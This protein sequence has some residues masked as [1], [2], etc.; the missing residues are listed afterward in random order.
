MHGEAG[1]AFLELPGLHLSR[2]A[3]ARS[4]SIPSL[5][6][7]TTAY[8]LNVYTGYPLEILRSLQIWTWLDRRADGRA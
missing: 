7:A 1:E 4:S 2:P 3:R 5:L 8:G 6:R